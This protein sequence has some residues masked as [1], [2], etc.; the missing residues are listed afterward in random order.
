MADC[1]DL[2]PCCTLTST[3]TRHT[4]NTMH[5]PHTRAHACT[6]CTQAHVYTL[7]TQA[8][9]H[10]SA[11]LCTCVRWTHMSRHHSTHTTTHM[12][13]H[14]LL[15]AHAHTTVY[16]HGIAHRPAY[17]SMHAHSPAHNRAQAHAGHHPLTLYTCCE[18]VHSTTCTCAHTHPYRLWTHTHH[19]MHMLLGGQPWEEPHREH[20]DGCPGSSPADRGAGRPGRGGGR[21]RTQSSGPG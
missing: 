8:C 5:G 4:R 11:Q 13:A 10:H 19:Y 16:T 6:H 2:S 20:G 21:T 9:T 7:H 12:C 18:H 17:T 14:T 1:P 3:P 15:Y